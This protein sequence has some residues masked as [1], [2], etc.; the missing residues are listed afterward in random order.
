[1]IWSVPKSLDLDDNFDIDAFN[2]TNFVGIRDIDKDKITNFYKAEFFNTAL[3]FLYTKAMTR[4]Y[5]TLKQ[6]RDYNILRF[7]IIFEPASVSFLNGIYLLNS[8]CD[9]GLI[10]SQE[11][12]ELTKLIE[13]IQAVKFLDINKKVSKQ[14]FIYFLKVCCQAVFS[15][16]YKEFIKSYIEFATC[17]YTQELLPLSQTYI[18][19]IESDNRKIMITMQLLCMLVVEKFNDILDKNISTIIPAIANNFTSG[20][21]LI[22]SYFLK[23]YKN[24]A[25]KYI[26]LADIVGDLKAFEKLYTRCKE[27]NYLH[28]DISGYSIEPS[29]LNNLLDNI[30]VTNDYSVLVIPLII[31][32]YVGNEYAIN[33][34]SK[35]IAEKY[36]NAITIDR[37]NNYFKNHF[38]DNFYLLVSL[39]D[40][41]TKIKSLCEMILYIYIDEEVPNI[42]IVKYGIDKDYKS[43]SE[44]ISKKFL[45]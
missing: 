18:D 34:N 44:L 31:L 12:K 21:K 4:L 6:L 40:S 45:G 25:D 20:Q 11:Y 1:M 14:E 30:M 37:W 5:N 38:F 8:S 39:F 23:D 35:S 27:I 33:V 43:I 32:A 28:Y 36:I 16:D 26:K 10:T 2:S 29:V 13:F 17:L 19:I 22:Y 15:K 24:Y 9:L 41:K 42:G 3:E 7:Y